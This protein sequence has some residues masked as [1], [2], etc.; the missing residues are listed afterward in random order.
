LALTDVQV[1]F[2]GGFYTLSSSVLGAQELINLVF[3]KGIEIT[4]FRDI[5]NSTKR[6]FN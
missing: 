6:Y 4:Y 3:S 5:T 1:Q 2:N